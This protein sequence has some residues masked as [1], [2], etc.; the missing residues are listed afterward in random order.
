M[1]IK[2]HALINQY[3]PCNK[4]GWKCEPASCAGQATDYA[5]TYV[6]TEIHVYVYI[7]IYTCIAWVYMRVLCTLLPVC[8]HKYVYASWL[9]LV[10]VGEQRQTFEPSYCPQFQQAMGIK[11]WWNGILLEN[12]MCSDPHRWRDWKRSQLCHD[13]LWWWMM[14][15]KQQLMT[16]KNS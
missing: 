6:N 14:M 13:D 4:P 2:C 12:K 11:K 5:F 3:L 10:Q 1:A 15:V 16:V 9:V 8:M 7:F